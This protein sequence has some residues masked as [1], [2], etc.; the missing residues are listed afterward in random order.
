M[1]SLWIR[2]S[3]YWWPNYL[4]S[5]G[6]SKSLQSHPLMFPHKNVLL[7]KCL[8]QILTL[9]QKCK[10]LTWKFVKVWIKI[11]V[12]KLKTW[13]VIFIK[14]KVFFKLLNEYLNFL[15]VENKF[16]VRSKFNHIHSGWRKQNS[17]LLFS[18]K[19]YI[20]KFIICSSGAFWS[21]QYDFIAFS[22]SVST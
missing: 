4:K 11:R 9:T 7:F 15:F 6:A 8:H 2:G 18:I 21:V 5:F 20:T 13:E 19:C 17:A 16:I 1:G 22:L 12:S 10:R 14:I 3:L